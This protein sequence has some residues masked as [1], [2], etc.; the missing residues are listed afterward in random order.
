MN[1][2]VFSESEHYRY[3]LWRVWSKTKGRVLFV[4]L[5]PSTADFKKND[6]TVR[7]CIMYAQKWGYGSAEVV[8][9]FAWR[10][11]DPKA[12]Y[13]AKDP[14]GPEN[15]RHIL[16]AAGN[17]QK[18]ICAWGAHGALKGR[19]HNVLRMLRDDGYQVQ[20][21]HRTKDGQPGHPLYLAGSA[22][23]VDFL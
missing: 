7:K 3:R 16:Q 22:V 11:T 9:I 13:D 14:V 19:G 21:L 23:P 17:A 6:P 12:L 8:N 15:D 5:N 2:A 4:M 10:S 20:A 18:I 1:G